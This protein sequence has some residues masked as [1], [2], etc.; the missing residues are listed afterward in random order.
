V[1]YLTCFRLESEKTIRRAFDAGDDAGA[2]EAEVFMN[3]LRPLMPCNF[4]G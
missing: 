1:V 4:E 3:H 2:D